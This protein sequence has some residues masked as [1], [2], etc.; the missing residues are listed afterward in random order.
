MI[1]QSNESHSTETLNV[2]ALMSSQVDGLLISHSVETTSFEH[3]KLHL[4]R[5]IP[6]VHFDRVAYELPTAKVILDNFR[7]S[8]CW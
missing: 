3:I 7:G 2:Q 1:C 5:G 6:I 8:F 4:N